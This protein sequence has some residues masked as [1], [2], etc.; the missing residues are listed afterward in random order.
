MGP[1]EEEKA[2]ARYYQRIAQ[3]TGLKA[4]R[5]LSALARVVEEHK[6]ALAQKEEANE[7]LQGVLSSLAEAVFVVEP[8][9][10]RILEANATA[11]RMFGYARAELI[12][13]STEPLHVDR[14]H[15]DRFAAELAKAIPEKGF[16]EIPYRMRR[17]DGTVFETEHYVAPVYGPGRALRCWVS[18][19]RDITE[20][21]RSEEALQQKDLMLRQA[22]KMEA[23][24]RLS[25]GISHEFNNILTGIVGLATLIKR[26]GGG[27]AA[28]DAEGI[29]ASCRRAADVIARLKAF[30][31]RRAAAKGVVDLNKAAEEFRRLAVPAFGER[32][33][34]ELELDPSL[35]P[36]LADA[37]QV[38]QAL[39]NLCLNAK[40]ALGGEGA[41]TV[42]TRAASFE[43]PFE[44]PHGVL[45]PGRYALLQVEDAGKGISAEEAPHV[46]LPF[47]TTKAP[48]EGSGLGL[49][50]VFGILADH[51]G[52]VT[53]ESAAG[54]G[55]RFDTYWPAASEREKEAPAAEARGGSETVLVADDEPV[56]L[57]IVRR[58]L[59]PRG[60]KLLFAESG[61]QAVKVFRAHKG[62]VALLLFDVVMPRLGGCEA[63]RRIC[64]EAGRK[65]PV[66]LMSG[67]ATAQAMGRCEE[68]GEP[69]IQKPFLPEELARRVRAALDA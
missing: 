51:E 56:V 68:Y 28:E 4:L 10:R 69:F 7:L 17:K 39:M 27:Q 20:R 29:I 44:T 55:A 43:K 45:R 11:E 15:L 49:P 32:I 14:E 16:L 66:V 8:D 12:G 25:S 50:V 36:V 60:Y 5:E 22:Q 52:L 67:Y 48:G 31:Q 19:V 54:R 24:S 57:D 26:A 64:E 21:R 1:L 9:S 41:V 53:F 38:E 34:F 13:R 42:R 61:E 6:K 59:E 47:F 40:D 3:Q 23:V 18:V 2:K 58:I 37:G 46:F 62:E 33:R 63:H 30:S 65:V 35:P